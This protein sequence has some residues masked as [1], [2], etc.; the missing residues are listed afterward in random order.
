MQSDNTIPMLTPPAYASIA[1]Q[2]M[3]TIPARELTN[4]PPFSGPFAGVPSIRAFDLTSPGIDTIAPLEADP[5]TGDILQFDR[6]P[7]LFMLV[8]SEMPLLADQLMLGLDQEEDR[9]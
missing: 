4:A 1:G 2:G 6:P 3:P 5:V 7:G 8:A 9:S